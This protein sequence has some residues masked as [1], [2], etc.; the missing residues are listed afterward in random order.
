MKFVDPNERERR[1]WETS[2]FWQAFIGDVGKLRLFMKPQED[3]YQK[4]RNWLRNSCAPTMKMVL[5]ADKH[6]GKTDLSDMIV[7]AEL[8]DKHKKM[9]DVF[10]AD[11]AD[12]VV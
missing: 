4:S 9:L 5:E 2:D 6:L 8:A 12:M 3:F 10:M 1:Y 11:V 7:E